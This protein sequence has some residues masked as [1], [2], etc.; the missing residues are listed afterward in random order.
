MVLAV[1]VVL[2]GSMLLS[3]AYAAEQGMAPSTAQSQA[4]EKVAAI[5][6]EPPVGQKAGTLRKKV[7]KPA[8][9]EKAEPKTAGKPGG[10]AETP[11]ES[12]QSVQLRGVRG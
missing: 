9:V 8:G 11:I 7:H 2:L 5:Q 4:Q 6:Q 10:A 1:R 3:S 12:M